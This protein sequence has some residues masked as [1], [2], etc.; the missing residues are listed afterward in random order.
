M[1]VQ[2]ISNI[3]LFNSTMRNVNSTQSSLYSLQEQISS[4]LKSKTYQG[5][6]GQV[7]QFVGLDARL[8]RIDLYLGNNSVATARLQT[9]NKAM[10]NIIDMTD[11]IEDLIVAARNPATGGALN[12]VQQIKDKL[13]SVAE[14]M[15]ISFEGRYLFSGTA[16]DTKPVPNI[17]I[18]NARFGVPDAGYYAGSPET[19]SARIDDGVDVPFPVR[20]DDIAF[21]QLFTAVNMAV[22]AYGNGSGS[23]DAGLADAVKMIQQAQDG[24]NAIQGRIGSTVL[25]VEQVTAR[26]TQLKL[27]WKGVVEDISKTDIVAATTKVA[28]DQATLQASYQ[29]FSRLVQLKLSD[30]L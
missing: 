6:N 20:A 26:Q 13:Q 24:M 1:A 28:N 5:L 23:N 17:N 22:T 9:A 3:M 15:N 2:R 18:D 10:D 19:V 16:T 12:F 29:V 14:A 30:Y 8:N 25:N 27:Y 11:Q 4:G 7:E 21:Q